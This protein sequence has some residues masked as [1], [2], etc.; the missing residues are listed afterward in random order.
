MCGAYSKAT[1]CNSD[2]LLA[3]WCC[4]VNVRVSWERVGLLRYTTDSCT[5]G[6]QTDCTDAAAAQ[7]LLD[8]S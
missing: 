4:N 6:R 8:A 5:A 3:G 7:Q 1:A 2:P